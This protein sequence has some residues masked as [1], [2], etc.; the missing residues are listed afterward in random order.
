LAKQVITLHGKLLKEGDPLYADLHCVTGATR[1]R[2]RRIFN[3]GSFYKGGRFYNDVQNIPKSERQWMTLNSHY[4]DWYDYSAFYPGLLYAIAGVE[5]D[6]D[7][8]TI[9]G[10]PRQITKPILNIVLNARTYQSAVRAAAQELKRRGIQESQAERYAKARA[11][12]AA[13]KKRNAP[14]EQ[15]FHGDVGKRLMLHESHLL[16]FNMRALMKLQI[17]FVPLHDALLVP[18]HKLPVLKAIMDDNLAMHREILT[19][20]G[21]KLRNRASD[22]RSDVVAKSTP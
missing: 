3:D 18:E 9:E 4:V 15:F 20:G 2:L 17:P 22:L 13:L 5:C 8:Y 11:I 12:I 7:P 19:E 10:W 14:I 1:I 6:G 21:H 16:E